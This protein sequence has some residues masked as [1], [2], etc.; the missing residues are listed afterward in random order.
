MALLSHFEISGSELIEADEKVSLL[1]EKIGWGQFF[2]CFSGH[3]VEVTKQFALSLKENVAQIGDFR[4]IIDEEKF[5]EATKLPQNGERWFKGGKVNKKKC[6]SLPLPLP[7]TA[8]LKIGVSVRFLK[9]EWRAFYE[10]LVRYVSCDGRFSHLHYYH[11]RLLLA[12]KGCKLNLPFYLWQSLK[13]MSH[14]VQSFGNTD[15]SL[16]HH[17][18]VKIII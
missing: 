9:L 8:K 16:F 6:Q 4:F 14:S 12:L 10:I 13:K 1:F 2:R 3:N 17:G 18:L 15:R 7:A 11:L 5:A